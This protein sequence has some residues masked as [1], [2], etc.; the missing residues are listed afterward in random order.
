MVPFVFKYGKT[1]AIDFS[2]RKQ[3]SSKLG[4]I[5]LGDFQVPYFPNTDFLGIIIDSKLN[6]HDD[7]YMVYKN[8]YQVIF[9]LRKLQFLWRS[10]KL[11]MPYHKT[12][13]IYL[14]PGLLRAITN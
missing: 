6:N 8:F 12:A 9:L 14:K 4:Q 11:T 2:L 13:F 7:I 1:M 5:S 3:T 10:D